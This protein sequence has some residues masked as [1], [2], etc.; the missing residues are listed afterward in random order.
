MVSVLA[1]YKPINRCAD[2]DS[3]IESDLSDTI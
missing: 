1:N 2:A 3:G